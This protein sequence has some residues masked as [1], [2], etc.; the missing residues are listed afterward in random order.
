MFPGFKRAAPVAALLV[1][2]ALGF[3]ACVVANWPGHFPPDAID[4]LAQGRAGVFDFWHPPVMAWLLGL[5]DRLVPGAPLFFVADAALFFAS[6]AALATVRGGRWTA[7]ALMA[8]S[9]P[10]P[11]R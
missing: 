9:A 2:A 10:R 7:A 1:A 3:G 8:R 4:Q 6:L 5:A 11:W